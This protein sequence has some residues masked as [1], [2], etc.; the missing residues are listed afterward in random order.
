MQYDFKTIVENSNVAVLIFD[1]GSRQL[2]YANPKARRLLNFQDRDI[3]TIFLTDFFIERPQG[4]LRH[5]SE[6]LCRNP[7]EYFDI[8]ISRLDGGVVVSNLAVFNMQIQD[9]RYLVL[10]I[11]DIT[12][13]HKLKREVDI[14]QA[15]LRNTY[16]DLNEQ[17]H[18]LVALDRAK[19]RFIALVT[20]ELRTPLS[21]IVAT[22]DVL[23]LDMHDD[24]AQQKEFIK[25]IHEQ[26]LLLQALVNDILDF[27]KIQ[28]GKM[29]YYVEGLDLR[30]LL[31]H[32]AEN[33]RPMA[34]DGGIKIHVEFNG[35]NNFFAYY[36]R[37]RM[38][39]VIN[40]IL[41]NAIKYNRRGGEVFITL[42]SEN[43]DHLL[44]TVRDTGIGIPADKM[45]HVF[46]EFET[47]GAINNHHKGTG[48]GMPICKRLVE[49]MGGEI[50]LES[51][52]NV[53]TSFFVKIPREK[54]LAPD[55]YRSR[56]ATNADPLAS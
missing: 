19:D 10:N 30:E 20:H 4:N 2:G 17:N 42:S 18:R 13:Q 38:T 16:E 53:G 24:P 41:S 14:K 37:L 22:V 40:N 48:L 29:E 56:A 44:L 47:V 32:Q 46:N 3:T 49:A 28:A 9:N 31:T 25:M 52:L 54:V 5:L 23:M 36:D 45:I 51:E 12:I 1:G 39:E 7:G 50:Y 27:A 15:M 21:A 33:Y 8:L 6:N 55:F 35:K 11:Q 26:S 43:Q 34:Q